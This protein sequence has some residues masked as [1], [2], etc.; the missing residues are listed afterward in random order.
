MNWLY[1]QLLI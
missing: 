1:Y